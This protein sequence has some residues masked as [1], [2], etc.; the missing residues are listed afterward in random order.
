MYKVMQIEIVY[1]YS[2][3]MIGSILL[4]RWIGDG[5]RDEFNSIRA[6]PEKH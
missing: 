6:Q 2:V 1:K 3:F 4:R 5:E